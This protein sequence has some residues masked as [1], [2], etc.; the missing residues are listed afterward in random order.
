MSL[1]WV[2][3]LVVM[4]LGMW[5]SLAGGAWG[6]PTVL[7]DFS[8]A[9]ET[10]PQGWELAVK[11]G[12]AHLQ[13]VQ[14]NGTQALQMRSEQASFALQKKVDIALQESPFLVWQWKVTEL[15]RGGDFRHAA[16]DDQAAQLI[17]A[18]SS[19]RILS[20]I[21]DSTAPK[22]LVAAAQAPPLK[23]I[24]ALVVQS[25]S[26][27]LGAWI[28]ERRNLIEDYRRAFGEEPKAIGGVRI[29]INSQHTQSR[30]EAYWQ[31]IAVTEKP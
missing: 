24:F 10:V 17:V 1:R 15:P 5:G 18:F 28:T 7:V 12:A 29:Q 26:Q 3:Y 31:S 16:T 20:Y 21:W 25:G 4:T 27:S 22:G 30:A 14:D 9:Q 11:S 8:T 23:K 13:L 2:G 19:Q 6:Q